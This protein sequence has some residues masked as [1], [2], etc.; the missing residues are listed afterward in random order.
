MGNSGGGV[1]ME[2]R[3]IGTVVFPD[4]DVKIFMTASIDQR[5]VRRRKEYLDKGVEISLEDVKKNLLS[6]DETDSGREV[7]PLTIAPGAV[8]VNTS[9]VTIEEQVNIILEEI[10]KAAYKKG[11]KI[12]AVS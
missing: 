2:G 4:A 11:I 10:K 5:A 1:V 12:S 3:D 9:E 7:S 8:E 6:R